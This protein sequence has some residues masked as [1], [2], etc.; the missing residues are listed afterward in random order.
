LPSS[1][2]SGS[3]GSTF[4]ISGS[5]SQYSVPNSSSWYLPSF[6]SSAKACTQAGIQSIQAHT[7]FLAELEEGS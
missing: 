2:S 6:T 5:Y 4:G 3:S 7:I 1:K